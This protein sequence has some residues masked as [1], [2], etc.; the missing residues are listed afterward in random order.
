MLQAKET[1]E[2]IKKNP[3]KK[4]TVVTLRIGWNVCR[5][6][7]QYTKFLDFKTCIHKI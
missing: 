1:H 6:Q 3:M 5:C 7:I 2:V 4:L